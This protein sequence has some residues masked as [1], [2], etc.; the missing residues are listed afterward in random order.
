M[1][2][3]GRLAESRDSD[4]VIRLGPL[5]LSLLTGI[6]H[7]VDITTRDSQPASLTKKSLGR[8]GWYG[9]VPVPIP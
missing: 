6:L 1:R 3:V 2:H 9:L 7:V 5:Y 8:P 4:Y